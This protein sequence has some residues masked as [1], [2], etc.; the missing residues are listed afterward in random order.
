MLRGIAGEGVKFLSVF[1]GS[2]SGGRST[3]FL[4]EVKRN[5]RTR[6]ALTR[7][8]HWIRLFLIF[9]VLIAGCD[10]AL[11]V[12]S[13][14]IGVSSGS[15]IYTDGYLDTY[16]NYPFDKV[17]KAC[18]Q[19]LADMKASAVE[20]ERKISSGKITA[21]AYDE[22]VQIVVEYV[23]KTQTSVSIRV[24][25]SGNNIASQLLHEKIANK[26]LKAAIPEKP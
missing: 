20:R 1:A 16:Y 23:S 17:W 19:T 12:G 24:G 7:K 14:T 18:E 21:I 2:C 9:I 4:K 13:R 3:R 10:T 6:F 25:V 22:K 5:M 15:F 26:L 11:T 8:N